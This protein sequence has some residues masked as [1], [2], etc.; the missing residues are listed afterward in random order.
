MKLELKELINSLDI[1]TKK[2]LEQAAQ[3]CVQRG[4]NEIIIEDV[5]YNM[6]ENESS[7]SGP[8]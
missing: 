7:I 5:L 4:G 1:N 3:R 6:L 8:F 2:Y